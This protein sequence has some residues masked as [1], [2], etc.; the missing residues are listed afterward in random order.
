MSTL[1]P[2]LGLGLFSNDAL[3]CLAKNLLVLMSTYYDL[4][5]FFKGSINGISFGHSGHHSVF[6]NYFS[7]KPRKEIYC[8]ETQ[9]RARPVA[10]PR[11]QDAGDP[12]APQL[13]YLML[14]SRA[15]EN[16]IVTFENLCFQKKLTYWGRKV[17]YRDGPHTAWV[18]AAGQG[19]SRLG[20]I[21]SPGSLF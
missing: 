8:F 19:V 13:R 6:S 21:V 3:C 18:R 14:F 9:A 10:T 12:G 16:E 4:F 17:W 5:F 15:C 7:S 20:G 2:T 11:M 1:S